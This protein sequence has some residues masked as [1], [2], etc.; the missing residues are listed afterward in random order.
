MRN[1]SLPRHL[2]SRLTAAVLWLIGGLCLAPVLAALAGA[3][4]DAGHPSLAALA[5]AFADTAR[6]AVLAANTLRVTLGTVAVALLIGVP[7]G[8]LGFRTDLPGR[9]A[10]LLG[11]LL[12]ACMPL[13]VT[14]TCWMALL[15]MPFWMYKTAGAAW[16]SGIA[17]APLVAWIAGVAFASGDRDL[18]DTAA[19]DS[20]RWGLLWHVILPQSIW[21]IAMAAGVVTALCFW[22]ITITDI[23]MVRTFA[24]EVLTQFQLGAGPPQATAVALPAIVVAAALWAVT[25]RGLRRY[26]EAPATGVAERPPLIRLGRW[27]LAVALLAAA[28]LVLF[29]VVPLAALVR[30]LGNPRNLVIAW[31][32][33]HAEILETLRVT[34]VAATIVTVLA[35]A[36]AWAA[37]RQP[38]S[39]RLIHGALLL[40]LSVPAPAV[41]IGLIRLLNRPGLAGAL[42]DSE[43]GLI[44]AYII[45]TLPFAVIVLIPAMRQIP[46]DAEDAA[47]LDGSN[48]LGV[49]RSVVLP[50]AWQAMLAAWLLAFVLSLAEMGASFLVVPPG[51]VTLTTRFFTLIH[52]GVYPDAAGVCLIL[53]GMVGL[54]A[55]IL[56]A[57]VWP[58]LNRAGRPRG[59]VG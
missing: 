5:A 30:T 54:P 3:F 42:Y 7:L 41:G 39:R 35:T 23:L 44:L 10:L 4:W 8:F 25:L 38:V 9:A 21:G 27:R 6:L 50:C 29:F 49:M 45:R 32:V 51:H 15:G 47:V 40:M 56:A 14:A 24:E 48:W 12:A 17:Y 20:G 33:A 59:R 19:Q 46:R 34:P 57:L 36:A 26:G 2:A 37:A 16:I 28:T 53:V 52:Y 13:Y 1:R 18:E 11:C 58:R 31:R 43:A 55:A 22:D